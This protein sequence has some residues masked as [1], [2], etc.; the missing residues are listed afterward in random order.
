MQMFRKDLENILKEKYAVEQSELDHDALWSRVYPEIKKDK[1]R[2]FG[3]WM[4]GLGLL[5]LVAGLWMTLGFPSHE[6]SN[7]LS[8]DVESSSK[9][10]AQD[11]D[12][13][14]DNDILRDRAILKQEE[15]IRKQERIDNKD[16]AS[17][18]DVTDMQ[19]S[20]STNTMTAVFPATTDL[21]LHHT[22]DS[23]ATSNVEK[24]TIGD[25]IIVD[26]YAATIVAESST[27][28]APILSEF[29]LS[30]SKEVVPIIIKAIPVKSFL[31]PTDDRNI[32]LDLYPKSEGKVTAA[33]DFKHWKFMDVIVGYG[34]SSRDLSTNDLK[35]IPQLTLRES[36]EQSLDVFSI[37]LLWTYSFT[38][39]WGVKSGIDYQRL[40]DRATHHFE[41]SEI[42]SGDSVL[43]ETKYDANGVV[44]NVY[45]EGDELQIT[46][47]LKTRYNHYHSLGIPMTLV[48]SNGSGRMTYE[49]GAGLRLSKMIAASGF[50]Q[51]TENTEYDLSD[52]ADQLYGRSFNTEILMDAG[53][54]YKLSNRLGW[55]TGLQYRY[56]LDGVNA[57]L[58]PIT[59]K[60]N[61]IK[62]TTGLRYQ[63]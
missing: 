11:A 63:F 43:L 4:I 41:R 32:N 19:K 17:A 60:Y 3:F 39:H 1:K 48:Y 28:I 62:I 9:K 13:I 46:K 10:I 33:C 34:W 25:Q 42:I 30:M 2:P 26:R 51:D 14:S 21:F 31:L 8:A 56:G 35:A 29:N 59:Q 40:T 5:I 16:Y 57:R 20:I 38:D 54:L 24:Q 6:V 15:T 44:S 47:T 27:S 18:N 50:I 52:D 58:N 36:N 37:D 12:V 49:I 45:G 53:L 23:H 7:D 61:L 55:R 22:D